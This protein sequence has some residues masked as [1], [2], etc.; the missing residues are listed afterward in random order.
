MTVH[1]MRRDVVAF[2]RLRELVGCTHDEFD[3]CARRLRI[4]VGMEHLVAHLEGVIGDVLER[5]S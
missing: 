1:A 2:N 3:P 4:D 5:D